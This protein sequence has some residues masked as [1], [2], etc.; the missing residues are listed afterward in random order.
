MIFA[1]EEVHPEKNPVIRLAQH[2]AVS[3][4]L[5]ERISSLG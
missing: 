2:S 1:K 4:Q 5:T 3:A